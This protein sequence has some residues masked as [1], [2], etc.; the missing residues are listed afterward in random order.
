M[1]ALEREATIRWLTNPPE[2][3]P[4]MTVGSGSVSLPLSV[5]LNATHPLATSPAE[6]LAG[7]IGSIFAWFAARELMDGGTQ[8]HELIADVTLTVSE[9][10]GGVTDLAVSRLACKLLGRVPEI[11]EERL[12]AV[13]KLAMRRCVETVRLRTE[14]VAVTVEA[15]L[16][17]P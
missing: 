10:L 11:D 12:D 17:G 8:A 16:E 2:G 5:D 4:R 1:T 6:L 3:Q 7:A 9:D 13:A 14:R 15:I